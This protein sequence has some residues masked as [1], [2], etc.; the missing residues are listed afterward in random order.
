VRFEWLLPRRGSARAAS[1]RAPLSLKILRSG[2]TVRLVG[3]DVDVFVTVEGIDL[4]DPLDASF[5]AWFALPIAMQ[6]GCDLHIEAPLDPVV[7]A[8]AEKL[9]T[10]WQMWVPNRFSAVRVTG[11]AWHPKQGFRGDGLML[12]SGGVDSTSALLSGS[13]GG[14]SHVLTIQGSDFSMAREAAF[15]RLLERTAPLLE[16]LNLRRFILRTN[17]RRHV[18][19][20]EYTHGFILAGSLFVFRDLFSKGCFAADYTPEMEMLVFPWG[21][22]RVTNAYFA[23]SDFTVQTVDGGTTRTGKVR[24]IAEDALA[25]STLSLCRNDD[26]KPDNCG[27]CRK[28]LL[29]KMRFQAV[30]GR[31]PPIFRDSTLTARDVASIDLREP[32]A[33]AAFA[34]I[35]AEANRQ[36]G[37]HQ[38]PGFKAHLSAFHKRRSRRKAKGLARLL[39][40]RRTSSAFDRNG[41]A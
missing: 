35:E 9:S 1:P 12:Y 22:N 21:T 33:Y 36:A 31:V 29:T 28:C 6:R 30:A 13:G 40:Q 8:N 37:H 19:A 17:V 16:R 38:V 32:A 3:G 20:L 24:R 10:I 2:N 26:I 23:G 34:E 5:A 11:E 41:S 15:S 7:A 4:P 27:R 14:L 18:R 39:S 25:C